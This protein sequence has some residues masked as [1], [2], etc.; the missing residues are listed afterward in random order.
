MKMMKR[1]VSFLLVLALLLGLVPAVSA[2]GVWDSGDC[3]AEGSNVTWTLYED[4]ALVIKGS[5]AMADY[6]LEE[7]SFADPRSTAP[8]DYETGITSVRVE[9]GVTHV[10]DYAFYGLSAVESITIASSVRSIGQY[11]CAECFWLTDLELGNGVTTIGGSAFSS[12]EFLEKVYI[13][14]SVKTLGESAFAYCWQVTSLRIGTGLETLPEWVFHAMDN[15]TSVTI[16]ANVKSIGDFAFRGCSSLKEV[17]LHEGLQSIGQDAFGDCDMESIHI[18]ASVG[19]IGST[20][21]RD[22]E[23]LSLASSTVMLRKWHR[24]R[25]KA[26]HRIS[27][28]ITR[29]R[30]GVGPPRC[31]AGSLHI[32]MIPLAHC[33]KH[34]LWTKVPM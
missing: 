30:A 3:G 31:G 7:V 33:R 14:D 22:C 9:N 32:R 10:G 29:H 2:A 15:L 26:A 27:P 17:T 5:G 11:A 23:N 6:G 18:P 8:W 13:P 21:F 16:P 19:K 34:G 28:S 25:S 12:C 24:M 1:T 20:A 4:G